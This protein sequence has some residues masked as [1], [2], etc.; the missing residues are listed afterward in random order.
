MVEVQT[1]GSVA[2][3][4]LARPEVRNAFNSQLI[5]DLTDS[6]R[7]LSEASD[8]RVVVLSGEGKA[9]C[10][11][12]DINWMRASLDLSE[13][14]NVADAR[15]MSD[16]FRVIDRC[17]KPVVG[18]IHGAALGGGAGLVAVCDVAIAAADTVFGFTETKLGILPAVISPFVLA[19]IGV[20]QA[21]A[22]FLT[23]ERFSAKRAQAIGL[24]HQTVAAAELDHAVETVCNELRSAAPSAV[25]AAKET[26]VKVSEV[27]YAQTRDLT[28]QIIARQ[29]TTPE[30]QEGLR[31]FLERRKASWNID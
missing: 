6:F 7:S 4:R 30:G 8:V 25:A 10:G 20:S 2:S 1:N 23:G 12:A 22:L 17:G 9:F 29:R 16:M 27:S 5:A 14:D 31:A 3:I 11:G 24:I 13:E 21:R 18:K 26:I 28:A 19:K 15:R